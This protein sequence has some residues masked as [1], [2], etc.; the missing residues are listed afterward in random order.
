[1]GVYGGPPDMAVVSLI[2]EEICVFPAVSV[3]VKVRAVPG[4][5]VWGQLEI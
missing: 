1:M 3:I 5:F 4:G 2:L